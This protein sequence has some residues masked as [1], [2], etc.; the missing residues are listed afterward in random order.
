M[1][2]GGTDVLPLGRHALLWVH[3]YANTKV[4]ALR[5]QQGLTSVCW[6]K[7]YTATLQKFFYV[8]LPA[9]F[10]R[11]LRTN[12]LT[13]LW[14]KIPSFRPEHFKKLT[15]FKVSVYICNI[16]LIPASVSQGPPCF[17]PLF[18]ILI[19]SD[20]VFYRNKSSKIKIHLLTAQNISSLPSIT[21]STLTIH[22]MCLQS[23]GQT[24]PANQTTPP[25]DMWMWT[26]TIFS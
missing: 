11:I 10:G 19:T 12:L 20:L 14:S 6:S 3:F 25:K 23:L 22:P 9:H 8:T 2:R 15:H 7:H 18:H 26:K 1:R 5:S 21:R 4:Y 17:T 13:V 16:K 24:D